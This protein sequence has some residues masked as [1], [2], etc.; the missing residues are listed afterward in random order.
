[1]RGANKVNKQIDIAD[2]I[3]HNN[4]SLIGILKSKV[5]RAGLGLFIFVFFPTGVLLASN[6]DWH[7]GG[8]IFRS[9]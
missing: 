8:R 4:I 3:R 5:K 1:M 7:K 6:L 9:R 2:F